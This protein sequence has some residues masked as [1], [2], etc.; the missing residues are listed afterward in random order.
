SEKLCIECRIEYNSQF[1]NLKDGACINNVEYGYLAGISFTM[2]FAFV[3][4]FAGR[5]SDIMDRRFLHTG[6]VLLWSLAVAAHATCTSFNCLLVSRLLVGV[7]EAFNAP[8]CYTLISAYFRNSQRAT[9]NGIYS[10][11]TYLGSA[12][13]SLCLCLAG[14]VGWRDTAFLSGCFGVFMA[15]VLFYT[16][17]QDP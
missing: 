2:M 8:A 15:V 11:G 3:G 1:Y 17:D 16:V 13:S 14:I 4:L 9:A 10:T 6:A 5:V 7:G 12:M